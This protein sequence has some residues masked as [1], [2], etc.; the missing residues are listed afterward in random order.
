MSKKNRDNYNRWRNKTI[1]FRV[2]PEENE[3]I[4]RMVCLTGHTK[5]DYLT[6]NMLKAQ[7][8]IVGNPKVYKGLKDTIL[9]L[10]EELRRIEKAGDLS[11]EYI[12]LMKMV[13]TVYEGLKED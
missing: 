10:C 2:S 5:Q 3:Q 9:S 7:I 12:E 11:P 13:F 4:E 6:S 1:A 8:V